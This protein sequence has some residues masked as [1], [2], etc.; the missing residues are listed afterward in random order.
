MH[1]NVELNSEEILQLV[2]GYV[3]EISKERKLERSL[4]LLA[5]MG[6]ELTLADRCTLWVYD[7]L[8]NKIWTKVAHG[9]E[10]ISVGTD[11]GLVAYSIR[12]C[13]TIIIDDAYLDERFNM[14]VDQI[15]GY[16]TKSVLVIPIINLAGQVMGA[17]QAINKMTDKG[18]FNK[19]DIKYITLASTYAEKVMESAQL[20]EEI[21]QTQKDLVFLLGQVSEK[22]SWEIGEHIHRVADYSKLLAS[23]YGMS[24]EQIELIYLASPMHDIGK[25]AIE[26]KILN[27]PGPLTKVEYDTVKT[28]TSIGYDILK[29]SNM[30]ILKTASIIAHE[31][32]EKWDGT[33]YPK[34]LK[35]EEISIF[36]RI[37]AIADVFDALINERCYKKAFNRDKV[38]S[39]IVAERGRHFEPKLVDIF[40]DHLDEFYFIHD[41]YKD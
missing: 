33:G 23:K 4:M 21:E 29:S 14:E 18:V 35:E 28:H 19:R 3:A 1:N 32:H 37:T 41:H 15:T 38:V 10:T 20:H 8:N 27:K 40:M 34:G 16:H 36:G 2:F 30:T 5:D 24:D 17:Y 13:E 25:I 31:H 26:D 6:R 12:N 9:I 22:R 7:K 11:L 39:I